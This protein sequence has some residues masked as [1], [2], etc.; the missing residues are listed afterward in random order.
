M[1][2]NKNIST[3]KLKAIVFTDIV[4]FTNI[5]AQ[6]EQLALDLIDK[7]RDLLKP[8]VLKN[9]GEWL[10]EIG[11]GLLFSFDS[12]LDAVQCSIEIQDALKKIKDFKIR[13]GIHQG[14]IFIKD[15]DVY[16]DDVNIASR[17]ESFAPIGGVALSDKVK[18]DIQSVSN[19]KTDFIGHRKLKGVH[20]ETK[21][22]CITSN[23]LP[24]N[25]DNL[26]PKIIEYGNL[27]MG[28]QFFIR[29]LIASI[30]FLFRYYKGIEISEEFTESLI[31]NFKRSV[32][33]L[34]VG[35]SCLSFYKGISIKSQKAIYYF[36]I[37][38]AIY[39]IVVEVLKKVMEYLVTIPVRYNQTKLGWLKRVREL[40]E[41]L[42]MSGG[43]LASQDDEFGWLITNPD[44]ASIFIM[45]FVAILLL[46]LLWLLPVLSMKFTRYVIDLLRLKKIIK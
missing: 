8:I 35:Y 18:R 29:G 40:Q 30:V 2:T 9:H 28:Y 22:S 46:I 13:I 24:K 31:G 41:S 37:L 23:D 15:G 25:K 4:G 1:M 10:K 12:S 7:Q 11:D 14:D 44:Y 3:K 16:G 5:S 38:N 20:Q 17:I 42:G 27:F 32:V 33:F 34:L 21:I 26:I 19:I 45:I 36:G 39:F 6:N 43:E